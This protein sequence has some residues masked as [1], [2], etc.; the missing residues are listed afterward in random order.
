MFR[1]ILGEE[2][3]GLVEGG[4]VKDR[5]VIGSWIIPQKVQRIILIT[6]E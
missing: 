3:R 5:G 4:G 2:M 6:Y 1:E